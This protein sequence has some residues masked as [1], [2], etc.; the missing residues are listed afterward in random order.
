MRG[1]GYGMRKIGI[2]KLLFL[3]VFSFLIPHIP[4]PLYASEAPKRMVV[5]GPAITEMIFAMGL[6]DKIVGADSGSNYPEAVIALPKIGPFN[7]VSYEA[8]MAISPDEVLYTPESAPAEVFVRLKKEGVKA[9]RVGHDRTGLENLRET[10]SVLA[11]MMGAPEDG[12][13]LLASVDESVV[14]LKAQQ[15]K[16]PMPFKVLF[17][18]AGVD[19][20][21][22]VHG[23]TT[24]AHA[25][26][27]LAGAQNV[28]AF[29]DGTRRLL[30][31]QAHLYDAHIILT[32]NETLQRMGGA[33]SL[34]MVKEIAQMPAGRRGHLVALDSEE[35]L[36]FGPRVAGTAMKLFEIFKGQQ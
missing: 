33:S 29:H 9:T 20:I 34:L 5:V 24:P 7:D 6:G 31:E 3:A 19:G 18:S 28:A 36:G 8:I 16:N 32:T 35:L 10:I 26:L 4:Y 11:S 12:Q 22:R 14:K 13:V 1:M 21:L 17:V 27:D 15:H 2:K 30:P 23:R 25:M